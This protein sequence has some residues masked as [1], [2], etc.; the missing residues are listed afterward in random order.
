M[1]EI[2]SMN[3]CQYHGMSG[4]V[5]KLERTS[6]ASGS[7][8]D[9]WDGQTWQ[10]REDSYLEGQTA[11]SPPLPFG[12]FSGLCGV[13]GYVEEEEAVIETMP[14]EVCQRYYDG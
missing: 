10:Q 14:L 8:P 5:R 3:S 12:W 6:S 9:S 11:S 4:Q 2:V 7:R 13:N 1:A